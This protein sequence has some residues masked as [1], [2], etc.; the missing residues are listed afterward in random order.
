MA[1]LLIC[2]ERRSWRTHAVRLR[3]LVLNGGR[4]AP[5]LLL[6][7]GHKMAILAMG[8]GTRTIDHTAKA[9]LSVRNPV[10]QT[11][12]LVHADLCVETIELIYNAILASQ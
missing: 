9:S 10:L 4:A 6:S 8:H 5:P 11:P 1:G 3:A 2:D 12:F 7:Q